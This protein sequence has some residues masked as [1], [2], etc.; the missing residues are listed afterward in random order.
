[1]RFKPG[2]GY[3]LH[4]ARERLGLSRKEVE[5]RT[6]A[7]HFKVHEATIANIEKGVSKNPY[8]RSV[9]ALAAVYGIDSDELFEPEEVAS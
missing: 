4:E 1:M 7:N 5:D 9:F 3:R 8:P 6:K 2:A